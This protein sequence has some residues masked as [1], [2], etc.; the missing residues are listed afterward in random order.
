[1]KNNTL[2]KCEI[3]KLVKIENLKGNLTPVYNKIHIPFEVKRLYYLYDVPGG[4]TRGGHAH[5]GLEQLIV[6]VM[7]SFDVVLDDGRSKRKFTLN[8]AYIGLY[9]PQYI[10]RELENFSSGAICL[11]LA[12]EFYKESDYIR[13]YNEFLQIKIK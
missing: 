12:S 8:R 11:V 1:M 7:G 10:W 5:I 2:N 9:I 3:I 4:A 6:S 13:D